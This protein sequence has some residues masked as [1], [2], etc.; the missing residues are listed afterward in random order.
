VTAGACSNDSV[1]PQLSVTV[2]HV[3]PYNALL[4][5]DVN[6]LG[7]CINKT[8]CLVPGSLQLILNALTVVMSA[9]LGQVDKQYCC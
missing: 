1:V 6:A 7:V 2:T 9:A 3:T 4:A 5:Y 8:A